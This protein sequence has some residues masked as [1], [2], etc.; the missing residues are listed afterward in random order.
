MRVRNARRA[1]IGLIG[2][3]AL[4]VLPAVGQDQSGRSQTADQTPASPPQA[5]ANGGSLEARAARPPGAELKADRPEMRPERD[6]ALTRYFFDDFSEPTTLGGNWELAVAVTP[7]Q[8]LDDHGRP[9]A[10][11]RLG[12]DKPGPRRQ[13]E[14]R[15]VP[16]PLGDVSAVELSYTVQHRGVEAG[17]LL[18]V[19]YLSADGRWYPLERV[20]SDGRDSIAFSRNIRTLPDNALHAVCRIRFRPDTDDADDAW[21]LGEVSIAEYEPTYDLAVRVWPARNARVEVVPADGSEG[22]DGT[23]PFAR[24]L[25]AGTR[26]H[27]VAPPTVEEWVFSHWSVDG[28]P[29]P[30]GERVLTLELSR[31]IEAVAHYRPWIYGRSEVRLAIASSPESGAPIALG[32][33]PGRLYAEVARGAEYRG[34]TG[35]WLTLRASPRTECYV[36]IGWIVNGQALPESGNL[37]DHRIEGDDALLAEYALLGDMN[38]D[39]EL[40]KY[41]VDEFVLALIDP[42]GYAE[43]YPD[44]DR[45]RRGDINGDGVFDVLDVESLV[46]LMLND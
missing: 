33:E 29:V 31:S 25:Q 9:V 1:L 41:D 20:V 18:V 15:S 10:T 21:Y 6:A 7:V 40:D 13:P 26:V 34:L 39:D 24:A 16:V 3:A 42:A 38:G 32:P 46:D 8:E 12:G 23:T 19:E 36:F 14:L 27:L 2:L 37:L 45:T 5:R 35:E 43:R 44:L 11:V 28:T 4:G 22:L 17:E 30:E